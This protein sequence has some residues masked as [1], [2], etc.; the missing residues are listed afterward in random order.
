MASYYIA[1]GTSLYANSDLNLPSVTTDLAAIRHALEY[2]GF[3]QADVDVPE[4]PTREQLHQL[5]RWFNALTPEDEVVL[6]YVGHGR[7]DDQHYL[8]LHDDEIATLDLL[9]TFL[10]NPIARR[11]LVV[12]DTCES[13]GSSIDLGR[14]WDLF[15]SRFLRAKASITLVTSCRT[16]GEA[17]E[18][19]FTPRFAEALED[20]LKN[21]NQKRIPLE[22]VVG[23]IEKQ[24]PDW[25]HTSRAT[26][27]AIG[28]LITE[29]D[30]PNPHYDPDVPSGLDLE[31]Q[32]LFLEKRTHW[33]LRLLNFAG[34][35]HALERIAAFLNDE[36]SNAVVV[37]GGPGSGKS[38]VL[39]YFVAGTDIVDLS[40]HAK[41]RSLGDLINIVG[42]HFDVPLPGAEAGPE[43]QRAELLAQE[44]GQRAKPGTVIA[45][46]ALD[47]SLGAAEITR[48][49]LVGL[50]KQAN[51]R[52]LVGTRP[53]TSGPERFR[54]LGASARIVDLDS[55]EYFDVEDIVI[56]ARKRFQDRG[57]YIDQERDASAA[58]R[59]V[60]AKSGKTFLIAKLV[61]DGLVLHGESVEPSDIWSAGGP[62]DLKQVFGEYVDRFTSEAG[63][64][65]VLTVLGALAF[66]FG[67]G[68]PQRIWE[69][70][71]TAFGGDTVPMV[72]MRT[73]LEKCG[74]YIVESVDDG[75]S[76]YRLF[77]EAFSE[78]LRE[79]LGV[80][81][82]HSRI[83]DA[84]FPKDGNLTE[85]YVQRYLALHASAGGRL[86]ELLENLTCLLTA[87]PSILRRVAW[88]GK[89]PR[90]IRNG[91]CYILAAHTLGAS[92][93]QRAA[94]LALVAH[95]T[96]EVDLANEL[97][98][99]TKHASW[100]PRAVRW[101]P[102][103]PHAVIQTESIRAVAI[104]ER[105]GRTVIV[106][107]GDDGVVRLWDAETLELSDTLTIGDLEED[108]PWITALLVSGDQLYIACKPNL[109]Q[110]RR[111]SRSTVCA[112][113]WSTFEPLP[114]A[115]S[116]YE[117]P[118]I[119]LAEI[120]G[121]ACRLDAQAFSF[122]EIFEKPSLIRA[123]DCATGE[124]VL[125]TALDMSTPDLLGVLT[126]AGGSI[127][128]CLEKQGVALRS[129]DTGKRL[130]LIPETSV[131]CASGAWCDGRSALAIGTSD[132]RVTV[133][134][135]QSAELVAAFPGNTNY[136]D[137]VTTGTI[138]GSEVIVSGSRDGSLRIWR[139][140]GAELERSTTFP[141][142]AC[143]RVEVLETNPHWRVATGGYD[144]QPLHLWDGETLSPL[145]T[146]TSME[147]SVLASG[148]LDN[149]LV[150]AT[151]DDSGWTARDAYD[152]ESIA[153][154]TVADWGGILDGYLDGG[155]W[156]AACSDGKVR[157]RDIVNDRD[158]EPAAFKG[159]LAILAGSKLVV[160]T[161]QDLAWWDKNNG[162]MGTIP[163]AHSSRIQELAALLSANVYVLATAG[164]DHV[165]R[166]WKVNGGLEP[167]GE[168]LRG[169]HSQVFTVALGRL[170]NRT[171][172][173]AGDYDGI[174]LIWDLESRALL[175]SIHIGSRISA[176]KFHNQILLVGCPTGLISLELC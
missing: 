104:A 168:P 98:P 75:L 44:I 144:R 89:S 61:C 26:Y 172:V 35:S 154:G 87:D 105:K 164:S 11:M 171:I 102:I 146:E 150:L 37:T 69:Q 32:R 167:F 91:G 93:D 60:A 42:R 48:S 166:L 1:T 59:A 145:R 132:H 34:R 15:E 30:F 160:A 148:M 141:S 128:M 88:S 151:G 36:Q 56:Y 129:L 99:L 71:V 24:L 106:A 79:R 90:A 165:V 101:R 120:D 47:E 78:Y 41:G 112:F 147:S 139:R 22:S 18:G 174:L 54:G 161:E 68:L 113:Y 155:L 116:K 143:T 133:W 82:G 95:Q 110:S 52:L 126:S 157:V 46:D 84:L 170:R 21:R 49:L 134:D 118:Q 72:A 40:I 130:H 62:A 108:R 158:I 137:C 138:Q 25:Q 109:L 159:R 107:G 83:F 96:G 152:L 115:P 17:K 136:V 28:G 14:H 149:R 92:M 175:N 63:R 76:V 125:H 140:S 77:H 31:A 142:L 53:D 100:W 64:R 39:A 85:G 122:D 43:S 67:Q 153:G 123:R 121:R 65:E 7:T 94:Q 114:L 162:T 4:N 33:D 135:V 5:T 169:H 55:D 19:T 163:L 86:D 2:V 8:L 156:A 58:A 10:R 51:L 176:L 20:Q 57:L 73:V 127:A 117:D 38:S 50:A 66:G 119:V 131:N 97:R 45:I 6:Y 3:T 80:V 111:A 173:A 27:P 23:R 13:G 74:A 12:L 81:D 29:F 124:V 70:C 9:R 16:G 103:A